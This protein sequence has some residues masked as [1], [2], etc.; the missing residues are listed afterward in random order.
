MKI[1]KIDHV[2]ITTQVLEACIKFYE[3][4]GF[5]AEKS[6]GRFELFSGDFKI[7]VH[8][9]NHELS[10]HARHIQT[11]SADMCFELTDD[12]LEYKKELEDKGIM[13]ELEIVERNGAKG[14]MHSFYVRDPD[15]N[16]IEFC[17]YS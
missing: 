13:I 16:L 10:P 15:E 1:R 3:K 2:V 7:N 8:V 9:K 11:G 4:I 5:R 14:H 6:S 17:S 12:I